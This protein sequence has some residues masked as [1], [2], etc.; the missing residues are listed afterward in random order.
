M[1]NT[2]NDWIDASIVEF[3]FLKG[4]QTDFREILKI[5]IPGIPIRT[6]IKEYDNAKEA[7]LNASANESKYRWEIDKQNIFINGPIR[8]T[9]I[10][11]AKKQLSDI[12]ESFVEEANLVKK[13]QT[14]PY[15]RNF[16]NENRNKKLVNYD[17]LVN[18]KN[19]YILNLL[20]NHSEI[21]LTLQKN[22]L[23]YIAKRANLFYNMITASA[24]NILMDMPIMEYDDPINI[25]IDIK[26]FKSL[27]D[28]LTPYQ[29]NEFFNRFENTY[30]NK[31]EPERFN[32]FFRLNPLIKGPFL[33]IYKKY[34]ENK[35]HDKDFT[36]SLINKMKK[37]IEDALSP[38]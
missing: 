11:E 36:S 31:K 14:C 22:S 19:Y 37:G 10:N 17:D 30:Y 23:S 20:H 27:V 1:V 15:Y 12:R 33:L 18:Y 2:Q 6:A 38:P 35:Y 13:M 4:D 25:K 5:D 3:Q 16:R 8:V 32:I 9:E 7:V 29:Q 28:I 26:I 24:H 21:S 34:L